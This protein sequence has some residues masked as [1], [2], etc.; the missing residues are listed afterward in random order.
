MDRGASEPEI[1]LSDQDILDAMGEIDGYLDISTADARAVY[2][3]AHRHALERLFQGM[4]AAKLMRRGI[5]PLSVDARLDTAARALVTQGVKGLPVV[6]ASRRVVGI[7]TETD[8]LR[9]LQADSFLQL[10]LRIVDGGEGFSH[11]C[12]QTTVGEV[13]R[14]PAT[15][16]AA[17][18]GFA[19]IVA[20]FQAHAGRGMPV[21]EADGQ[22]LGLLLRKDVIRA[23]HL[24]APL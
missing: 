13:M 20:A 6:D 10:L 17:D 18:A 12:H 23:C 4:S 9:R 19:E 16:V 3:L 14:A 24:E 15:S 2:Q 8:F 11:H 22:L 5:S 1:A 7:L 21:V